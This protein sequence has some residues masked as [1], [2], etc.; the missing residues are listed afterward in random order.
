MK[1]IEADFIPEDGYSYVKIQ[2]LGKE[3]I[4]IANVHPND[5]DKVSSFAGCEY[6]EIRATIRA[7]KYE[8]K[9]ARV[10]EEEAEKFVRAC[11]CYKNFN[12]EDKTAKV[13][14]RQLNRRRKR[15]K[16]LVKEINSLEEEL[17]FLIAQRDKV[18]NRKK[19]K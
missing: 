7:L 5:K 18:I 14:F 9:L 8:L 6:A 15:V 2:H 4:G 19:D 17:K 11:L 3:F 13:I 10:E 12:K 1:F 16:D